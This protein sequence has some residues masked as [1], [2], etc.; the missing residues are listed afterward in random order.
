MNAVDIAS[1]GLV[2]TGAIA[3]ALAAMGFADSNDLAGLFWGALAAASLSAAV[4]FSTG[5]RRRR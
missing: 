3:S 2:L 5:T 1:I 4:R